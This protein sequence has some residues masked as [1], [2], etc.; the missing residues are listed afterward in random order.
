MDKQKLM[1]RLR[2]VFQTY[3]SHQVYF[4]DEKSIKD[5]KL[6]VQDGNKALSTLIDDLA[7][8]V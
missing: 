6:D 4:S 7:H 3:P 2:V 5:F 1:A 8:E